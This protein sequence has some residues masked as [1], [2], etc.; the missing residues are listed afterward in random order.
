M[1]EEEWLVV[2]ER[3]LDIQGNLDSMNF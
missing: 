1:F 2:Q 3:Y